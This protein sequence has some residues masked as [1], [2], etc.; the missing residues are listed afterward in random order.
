MRFQG[1]GGGG[2]GDPAKRDEAAKA[3]DEAEGFA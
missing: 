2:W 3:R 1:A